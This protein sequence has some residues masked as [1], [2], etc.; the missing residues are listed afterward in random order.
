MNGA[1]S[2]DALASIGLPRYI[3]IHADAQ[4]RAVD[5]ISDLHL[6]AKLPGTFEAF[7]RHLDET[8]ADA[9]LILGDLFEAWVGD[10]SGETGFE[11]T[12][13]EAIAEAS[14]RIS[15]GFM[16]GNR[17]FLVGTPTL[18]RS[19]MFALADPT[20]IEGFGMRVLLTH[21]DALCLADT[22]Y[23]AFRRTVRDPAW[24][25]EFLARPLAER[26]AL[27]G[28]LRDE[29]RKRAATR[30]P[31]AYDVDPAS[32][33]RWLHSAGAAVLVHGHTHQ[34]GSEPLAPGYLRHVL[35]DWDCESPRPE[36]QR[37][38]VLRWSSA[39]FERLT[40][41]QAVAAAQPR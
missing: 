33:V 3:E 12:C 10:D 5:F 7:R 20:L 36:R 39:G 14:C 35:S 18:H 40:L 29:S 31:D 22:E 6:S 9:V 26:Q 1:P 41:Q 15:I 34:P 8:P 25:A 30:S 4:W 11:A 37:G 21:G 2:V 13:L 28:H 27:A 24:Q 16:H 38:D 19:G 17:D 32:A 23:Q